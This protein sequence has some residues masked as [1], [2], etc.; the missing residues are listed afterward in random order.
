VKSINS[1]ITDSLTSVLE[2]QTF[3]G[4]VKL[5]TCPGCHGPELAIGWFHPSVGLG[6]VEFPDYLWFTVESWVVIVVILWVGSGWV[7]SK[8]GRM[9]NSGYNSCRNHAEKSTA[10]PLFNVTLTFDL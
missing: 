4:Y 6:W 10:T 5:S 8:N 7:G 1:N 9:V 2:L 3:A